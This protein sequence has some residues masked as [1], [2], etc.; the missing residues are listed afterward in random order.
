MENACVL[1]LFG[2][3]VT[4]SPGWRV[5][6]DNA[7]SLNYD[8]GLFRFEENVKERRSRISMGLRWECSQTDNETFLK[9]FREN[10]ELEYHKA[11]KGRSRQFELL[12]S[13]VVENTQGYRMCIVETQYK[14]TQALVNNPKTMQRLRVCNAAL[15]C[16]ATH[17]IVICSLV[18][19]PQYMEENRTL[20]ESLLLSLQTHPVY[21]PEE[22]R[23]RMEKRAAL[24]ATAGKKPMSLAGVLHKW[25]RKTPEDAPA[26]ALKGD[27]SEAPC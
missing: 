23:L 7:Y 11:I 16:E 12:R 13:E 2:V 5:I 27:S 4:Y 25:R 18:T 9:E 14:A 3:Q 21:S 24:R 1:D 6:P 22:E 26:P 17:R 15:Y 10:I 19:T 20:L 8:S